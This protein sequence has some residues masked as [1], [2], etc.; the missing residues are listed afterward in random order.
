LHEFLVFFLVGL[1]ASLVDGA[2]GMAYGVTSNSFLLSMGIPPAI[3][4]AT[5]HTSEVGVTLVSGVSHLKLG[6]V[7]NTVVKKL[8]L[9]GVFFGILGAVFCTVMP[10]GIIKPIVVLYLFIVGIG[11]LWRALT[12]TRP[13]KKLFRIPLLGAVGGFADAVGGGGW[14]PVVSSS[15]VFDGHNPQTSIGSV[16]FTEFF[17]TI[18][19]ATAFFALLGFINWGLVIPFLAGGV[20][21]APF[22]AYI[23]KRMP[24]KALMVAI[25]ILITCLSIRNLAILI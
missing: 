4:S 15:L 16:N 25:G 13:A 21:V 23:C 20:I 24:K 11:I 1:F 9:P 17:V 22:A 2:L 5:I 18:A 14:G 8:L 6:N 3:S 10:V 19:Q 7:D 12:K